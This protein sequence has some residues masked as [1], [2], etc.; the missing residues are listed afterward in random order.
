MLE[1]HA[2]AKI[3]LYLH[4]TGK[5]DDGYHLLDSLVT[6]TNIGDR[7]SLEEANEFT[8]TIDGPMGEALSRHNQEDNLVVRAAKML[9][10][11]LDKP[12]N[13]HIN[14]TKKLPLASGIGGGSTD[15]A[16]ALRLLAVHWGLAPNAA[17]LHEVGA[18][19]GQDIP[20]CIEAKNCYFRDI[21]NV[22]DEADELSPTHLVLVNPGHD[23]STPSVFK[24]RT[25]DFTPA[26]RLARMSYSTEDLALEL[27]KRSN[28]LTEAAISLCPSIQEVLDVL[29]ASEGCLLSRMS[30]SGATCFGMFSNRAMARQAAAAIMEAKPTWWVVP[31]HIPTEPV[32]PLER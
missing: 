18:A 13:V 2:P 6:F 11:K 19:L 24:A 27:K 10:A 4:V 8:F 31:A 5:R 25:G 7:V 30:G 26:N 21:G 28:S 16:A 23:L 9:A 12:L 29:E 14:L 20:C 22:M 15:A 3:N 32:L 17:V 1:T